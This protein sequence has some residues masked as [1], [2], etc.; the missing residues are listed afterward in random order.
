MIMIY[1]MSDIHGEYEKFIT[2]IEKIK[3]MSQDELFVLG[4]VVDRGPKPVELLS[5]I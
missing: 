3:F 4:D 1:A 2:M 5:Y